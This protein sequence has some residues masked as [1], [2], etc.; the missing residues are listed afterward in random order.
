MKITMPMMSPACL[1]SCVSPCA[2]PMAALN[3]AARVKIKAKG[4]WNAENKL[5]Q[6][7]GSFSSGKLLGPY[8][9]I[10]AKASSGVKPFVGSVLKRVSTSE[11]GKDHQATWSG[12]DTSKVCGVGDAFT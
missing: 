8:C 2:N 4:S 9:L 5:D 1:S 10:R 7:P 6:T 12:G 11:T 3:T